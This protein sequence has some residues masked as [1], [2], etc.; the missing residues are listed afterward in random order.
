MLFP[1]SIHVVTS[2]FKLDGEARI[3]IRIGYRLGLE[4]GRIEEDA[5]KVQ[6]LLTSLRCG[7]DLAHQRRKWRVC[8]EYVFN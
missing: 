2:A 5:K 6:T 7:I 4:G 3:T 1:W 8:F